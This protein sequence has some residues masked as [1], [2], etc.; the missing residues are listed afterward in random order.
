MDQCARP[1]IRSEDIDEVE[2]IVGK[3][4]TRKRKEPAKTAF[5]ASLGNAG[6]ECARPRRA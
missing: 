3:L 6:S 2:K 5:A 1:S 4:T